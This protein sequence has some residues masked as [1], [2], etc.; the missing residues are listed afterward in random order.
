MNL[1]FYKSVKP[2]QA[3]YIHIPFCHS[4]CSYCDFFSCAAS[5]I[6][7]LNE[8]TNKLVYFTDGIL[9]NLD[10]SDIRTVYIGG[11]NPGILG[12]ENLFKI[13]KSISDYFQESQII[14]CTIELNPENITSD[15]LEFLKSTLVNRISLGVQ[16]FNHRLHKTLGRNSSIEVT[17]RALD[18]MMNHWEESWNA[19]IIYGI[20]DQKFSDVRFDMKSLLSYDP[21]HISLY[22][23]IPEPETVLGKKVLSGELKIPED[24][25][26]IDFEKYQR[27]FLDSKGFSHYE[28]S[29][30]SK[31]NKQS[32]HN[33][34]YWN[35]GSYLGIGPGSV[36]T[37]NT[38]NND[39]QRLT[40]SQDLMAFNRYELKVHQEIIDT[41]DLLKDWLMMNLRKSNGFYSV[42][43]SQVFKFDFIEK[44]SAEV[45]KYSDLDCLGISNG[46]VFLTEKGLN[47]F[48]D[49]LSTFFMKIDKLILNDKPFWP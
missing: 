48:N 30:F 25:E 38:D 17:I 22:A 27:N 26:I 4:K 47:L 6:D 35:M 33:L 9:K 42:N 31:K 16:T 24:D 36:S 14:E 41:S 39:I 8:F 28:I 46:R 19:D 20:P 49:I 34:N 5:G 23:L 21:D 43:F 11:G 3:L 18:V 44:F 12:I 7:V 1:S 29:N 45:E 13:H 40:W 10:T 32:L 2:T 37:I 15:M